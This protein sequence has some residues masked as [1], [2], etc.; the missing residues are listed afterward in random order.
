MKRKVITCIILFVVILLIGLG[1]WRVI[2][3]NNKFSVSEDIVNMSENLYY[4]GYRISIDKANIWNYDDYFNN[5]ENSEEYEGYHNYYKVDDKQSIIAMDLHIEKED[6]SD[7]RLEINSLTIMQDAFFNGMPV[8]FISDLNKQ[9]PYINLKKGEECNY[10][11]IYILYN[12][13]FVNKEWERRA[14]LEYIVV[15][16]T[17][18]TKTGIR[19]NK[20]ENNINDNYDSSGWIR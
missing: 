7:M 15:L 6:D 4:N 18:P 1:V 13:E 19:L 3:V 20:L 8:D 11:V 5:L 14:E 17:Y 2:T 12:S 10:K 9:V 16:E